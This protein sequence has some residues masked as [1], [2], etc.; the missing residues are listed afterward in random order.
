[1]RNISAGLCDAVDIAFERGCMI[2]A[3]VG[4]EGSYVASKAN[5]VLVIPPVNSDKLTPHSESFQ[6]V[7]WHLLVSHPRIQKESTTW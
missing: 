3:I 5:E 4:R 6:S 7:V 1:M 2:L